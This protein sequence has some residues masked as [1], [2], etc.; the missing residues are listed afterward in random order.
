MTAFIAIPRLGYWECESPILHAGRCY[1]TRIRAPQAPS[2]PGCVL[3][4]R[5]FNVLPERREAL[6]DC[7]CAT[8]AG[9]LIF[10]LDWAL[11]QICG[12]CCTAFPCI[13]SQL[14]FCPI[15]TQ[16][17]CHQRSSHSYQ[18]GRRG[19]SSTLV[20]KQVWVVGFKEILMRI[21]TAIPGAF[22]AHVE[23][24]HQD[25]WLLWQRKDQHVACARVAMFRGV[26]RACF[27]SML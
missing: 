21:R 18:S 1:Q 8:Y 17:G 9:S 3:A 22:A 5:T 10:C 27:C 13:L 4:S 26:L 6:K 12:N 11:E 19:P 2:Y 24:K 15:N 7:A 25:I 16:Q 20:K 23:L 14:P